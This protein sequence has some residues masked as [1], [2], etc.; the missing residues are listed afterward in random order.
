MKNFFQIVTF[1]FIVG[2]YSACATVPEFLEV[3]PPL[4]SDQPEMGRI[5]CYMPS[6]LGA[7]FQ[8]EV[9]LNDKEV[10]RAKSLGFFYVDRPPWRL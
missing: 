5:F 1:V 4:V 8:P 7:A 10:G 3:N 2:F 9:R 6:S